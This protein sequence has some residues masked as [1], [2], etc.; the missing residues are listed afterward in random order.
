MI[1]DETVFLKK[2]KA[3]PFVDLRKA[4]QSSACFHAHSHDELSFGVIDSGA[5]KYINLKKKPLSVPVIPSVVC[6]YVF[7]VILKSV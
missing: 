6:G 3:L 2:S 5:A 1:Q 4:T 7:N